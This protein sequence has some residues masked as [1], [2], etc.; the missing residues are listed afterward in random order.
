MAAFHRDREFCSG[1]R[2]GSSA[3]QPADVTPELFSKQPGGPRQV[4]E[5]ARS[6][7]KAMAGTQ[8]EGGS[9]KT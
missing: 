6:P 1:E 2:A 4:D 9:L 5:G 3:L 7:R 8:E